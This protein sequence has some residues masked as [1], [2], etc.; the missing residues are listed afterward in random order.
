MMDKYNGLG[1]YVH[2]I[3]QEIRDMADHYRS[4]ITVLGEL[5]DENEKLKLESENLTEEN[6]RLKETVSKLEKASSLTCTTAV[7]IIFTKF[8]LIFISFHFI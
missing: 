7:N 3:Q 4:T 1:T 6:V 5:T 8:R 2:A